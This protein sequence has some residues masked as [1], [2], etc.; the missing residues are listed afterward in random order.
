MAIA[1]HGCL[2]A[3]SDHIIVFC[4]RCWTASPGLA[5]SFIS[6]R[7]PSIIIHSGDMKLIRTFIRISNLE[8]THKVS[9]V[10]LQRLFNCWKVNP[11]LIFKTG[12][13]TFILVRWAR[14]N[15]IQDTVA[16]CDILIGWESVSGWRMDAI[17]LWVF[18]SGT[19]IP[20]AK[21]VISIDRWSDGQPLLLCFQTTCDLKIDF[22]IFHIL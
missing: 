22:L 12:A 4:V 13:W 21:P 7:D 6:Y 15:I 9:Q 17:V 2:E 19:V 1:L 11:T 16:H 5:A 10:K 18:A 3:S 20:Q 14:R 8:T